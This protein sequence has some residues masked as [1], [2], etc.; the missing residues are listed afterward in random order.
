MANYWQAR[1]M[2]ALSSADRAQSPQTKLAYIELAAHYQAMR[3]FCERTPIRR[4]QS[5]A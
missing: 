2:V 5:A 3:S 1:Y 4:Y